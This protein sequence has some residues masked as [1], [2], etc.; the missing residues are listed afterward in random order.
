MKYGA[1]IWQTWSILKIQKMVD[2]GIYSLYSIISQKFF[3]VYLL[4]IKVLKQSLLRNIILQS[5]AQ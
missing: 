4:R 2:S 1:L 3:D 5:T